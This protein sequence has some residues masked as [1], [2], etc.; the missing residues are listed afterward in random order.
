MDEISSSGPIESILEKNDISA[1]SVTGDLITESV[2]VRHFHN[3]CTDMVY[4]QCV[5][6]GVLSNYFF[7]VQRIS[8]SGL[9]DMV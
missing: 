5:L 9:T 4:F 1:K 2:W 8:H 7:F 3:G 6:L